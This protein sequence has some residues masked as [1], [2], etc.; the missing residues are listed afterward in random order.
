[1]ALVP[2]PPVRLP[3]VEPPPTQSQTTPGLSA[4]I[5]V[6]FLDP[7]R[8]LPLVALVL[9]WR[10]DY[11]NNRP[12]TWATVIS[13]VGHNLPPAPFQEHPSIGVVFLRAASGTCR[14]LRGAKGSGDAV[15]ER[16]NPKID[17]TLGRRTR[18]IAWRSLV[19]PRGTA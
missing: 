5:P 17:L 6:A 16:N 4:A 7:G 3:P 10:Q 8:R 1:M 19:S 14:S 13:A 12:P 2:S 15:G 11:P 9:Q 18:S